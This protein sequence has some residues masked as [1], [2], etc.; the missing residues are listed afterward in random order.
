MVE[1]NNRQD[2]QAEGTKKTCFETWI[3]ILSCKTISEKIN[4]QFY[5]SKITK[6]L[7]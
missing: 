1:A 7:K 2:Q 6:L 3:L 4:E 5:I